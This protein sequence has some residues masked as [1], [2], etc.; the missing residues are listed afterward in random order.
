MAVTSIISLHGHKGKSTTQVIK[1]CLNY[2][3]NPQKTENGEHIS[4]YKCDKDTIID[5]FMT[6]KK[7]YEMITNKKQKND[8]NVVGYMIRQSFK[9]NEI[10]PEKA[11]EI[12]YKLALEYTK[13]EHQFIVCT[14]TDKQHIHNHIIFNST[15]L[16]CDRKFN[17]KKNSY[18]TVRK[19][20]DELCQEYAL[21]IIENP[22]PK[23]KHYKEWQEEKKGNSWKAKLKKTIDEI[24]P[25]CLTF[26]AFLSAMQ[27]AG[28]EIKQKKHISFKAVGQNRFTRLDKLGNNYFENVLKEKIAENNKINSQLKSKYKSKANDKKKVNLIINIQE[29]I[30]SG[31]GVAYE[32][33]AKLFNLKE[34][35]KTLN[36]LTENNITQYDLLEQKTSETITK[37]N[38]ISREIKKKEKQMSNISSLKKHIINYMK[39]RE[40]YK[41]YKTIRNK[42]KFRNE[43]QAEIILHE[44]AKKA[45]NEL[46]T[47]K[48][49]SVSTLQK[50][51]TEL[52][53]EKKILYEDYKK[54]KIEM[55]Q[56]QNIKQNVE[57]IL[58]LDEQKK[59]KTEY[60][61]ER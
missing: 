49:P 11:N 15:N 52:F 39:T 26:D 8:K 59:Q 45:F 16:D 51:Y 4:S 9:P 46:N 3:K 5:E 36:Y 31:K 38:N 47:K 20:S 30:E 29:K 42:E 28:Y 27:N 6:S 41:E 10:T 7:L 23:G 61:H 19:I 40:I 57:I 55:N 14:H 33:W 12:G 60:N 44:S 17:N 48:L 34:A 50:Q 54:L 25:N 1:D 22:N 24:L 58:N 21:S 56:L 35:A 37:F 43:H 53:E 32:R 13:K 2:I 18:E